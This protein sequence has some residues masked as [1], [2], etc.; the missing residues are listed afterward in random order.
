M[1][2]LYPVILVHG[3]FGFGP[4]E[5]GEVDYW[6]TALKVASP[7][8]RFEA[9]V[10]PVSSAH[11]RACELAA[12]IKGTRVDYGEEH[13]A[14]EGHDRWGADYASKGF[15]PEWS[16]ER[17]VHLVGH[18]LGG[19]TVRCLQHLLSIDHF[20]WGSDHSWAHSVSAI[21]GVLN[22]STLVFMFGADEDSGRMSQE[23]IGAY[24]LKMIELYTSVSGGL[25]NPNKY[26][27]FDLGHWGFGRSNNET[28]PQY[29]NRLSDTPILWGE[30]NAAYSLTLQGAY[31]ANGLYQTFPDTYYFSY[32]TEKTVADP[33]TGGYVPRVD[34]LPAMQPF[35]LYIGRKTFDAAPIPVD[36]FDGADWQENDGLVPTIS[37]IYPHTKGHHPVYGYFD[38]EGETTLAFEKGGWHTA[39]IRGMDHLD[40]CLL[41]GIGLKSRQEKF[42]EALYRR[43]SDLPT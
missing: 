2:N 10:G 18:S 21:S 14:R 1:P 25:F 34:M 40:I 13:S 7:L 41:P 23:G 9:S 39:W 29:L 36:E 24:L 35:S 42:Y 33:I 43:L 12:Q 17:P 37:Q 20:G 3:L 5:M 4:D 32:V 19:P 22:G 30:D 15:H 26:Y 8:P 28:L 27:D 16:A 31:E 38:A 11:D 6:G